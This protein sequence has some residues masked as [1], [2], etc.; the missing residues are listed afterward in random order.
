[1]KLVLVRIVVLAVFVIAAAGCGPL[2]LAP[3]TPPATRLAIGQK[4][5]TA[6]PTPA[7]APTTAPTG[8]GGGG[9]CWVLMKAN[10]EPL[11]LEN[12]EEYKYTTTAMEGLVQGRLDWADGGCWGQVLGEVTWTPP[13]DRLIPGQV[14]RIEVAAALTGTHECDPHYSLYRPSEWSFATFRLGPTGY[15]VVSTEAKYP[16]GPFA[17]GAAY[18]WIIPEKSGG[19]GAWMIGGYTSAEG[20]YTA[21]AADFHISGLGASYIFYQYYYTWEEGAECV[22][23]PSPTP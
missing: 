5:D 10:S 4:E 2:A 7:A 22:T 3:E 8:A 15:G 23:G 21:L 11:R 9:G 16:N 1:M 17:G 14:V 12:D 18:E 6:A 13:P 19:E 20:Y